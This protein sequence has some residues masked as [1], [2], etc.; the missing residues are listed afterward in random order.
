MSDTL[1]APSDDPNPEGARARILETAS[2][3][4]YQH[5][6]R[7]VGIDRIIAESGVAKM[8]FYRH[9]PAKDDLIRAYLEGRH[10]RWLA[11]FQARLAAR[12]PELAAVA[13]ILL[14]WAAE[15]DYRGCAFINAVAEVGEGIAGVAAIARAHKDDLQRLL[16]EWLAPRLGERAPMAARC[17]MVVVE[18]L[19]VRSQ[20]GEGELLADDGRWLLQRVEAEFGAE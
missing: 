8:S 2:R 15:P 14:A 12:P 18:G 20:M 3:L 10:R 13:D 16:A 9:F 5:G 19:I 4:F 1:L 7:G 6:L 17:A 11:G